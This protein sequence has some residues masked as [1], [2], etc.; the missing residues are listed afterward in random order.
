[1]ESSGSRREVVKGTRLEGV[2]SEARESLGRR[3]DIEGRP[4]LERSRDD[5]EECRGEWN[6]S[7]WGSGFNTARE[8]RSADERRLGE[9]I[10]KPGV[11]GR[12]RGF[13]CGGSRGAR[14]LGSS[15]GASARKRGRGDR[16]TLE[17][18]LEG[19][20]TLQHSPVFPVIGGSPLDRAPEARR[21]PRDA[22]N[23]RGKALRV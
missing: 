19:R 9:P 22:R 16:S 15:G 10:G 6:G 21:S 4:T 14:R 23:G 20:L 2:S 13:G 11:T 7:F 5:D 12:S 1:V 18:C 17:S 8:T 3:V